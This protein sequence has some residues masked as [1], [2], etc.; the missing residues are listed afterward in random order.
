MSFTL[1]FHLRPSATHLLFSF[2]SINLF[3]FRLHKL[4][5]CLHLIALEEGL[6]AQLEGFEYHRSDEST[7][8][9]LPGFPTIFLHSMYLV[10]HHLKECFEHSRAAGV[11]LQTLSHRSRHLHLAPNVGISWWVSSPPGLLG[12]YLVHQLKQEA[13][14]FLT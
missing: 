14:S 2:S 10:D 7:H 3:S 11:W 5:R 6:S 1:G 12:I 13:Q 4:C 9:F 8:S